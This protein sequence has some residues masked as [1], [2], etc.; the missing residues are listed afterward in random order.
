MGAFA[1]VASVL[2]LFAIGEATGLAERSCYTSRGQRILRWLLI[3]R[4]R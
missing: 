1:R 4:G 2:V 3:V